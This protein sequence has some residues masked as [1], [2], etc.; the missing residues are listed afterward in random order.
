MESG[1]AGRQVG[2]ASS[3]PGISCGTLDKSQPLARET[4][5]NCTKTSSNL[6]NLIAHWE[7]KKKIG[8]TTLPF[9]PKAEFSR[10]PQW[11]PC[12]GG[13]VEEE[14]VCRGPAPS[15]GIKA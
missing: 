13:V 5:K 4:E 1:R 3:L 12:Q 6:H 8:E 14:E 2:R 7:K 10:L 9:S 11:V 15:F